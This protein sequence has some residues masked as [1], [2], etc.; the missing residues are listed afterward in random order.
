MT[1]A[2]TKQEATIEEQQEKLAQPQT[3][4]EL[5]GALLLEEMDLNLASR[6]LWLNVYEMF[7]DNGRQVGFW[8]TR[9]TWRDL[10]ARVTSVGDFKGPSPCFGNPRVAGDLFNLSSG[11]LKQANAE[12][13]SPGT[14]KTWRQ[15]AAPP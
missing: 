8:L 5:A 13:P 6:K 14:H 10:C 3:R 7:V 11:E 15:I 4:E 1:K 9:T 2:L 12:I